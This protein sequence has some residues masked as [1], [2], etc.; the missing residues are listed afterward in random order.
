SLMEGVARGELDGSGLW[1]LSKDGE[2][3]TARYDWQVETTKPW[4]NLIAPLAR[5]LFKWNHD[6]VM[7]W[8]A[9]GLARRLDAVVIEERESR[10]YNPLP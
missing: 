6:I 5:P 2:Y 8:G 10:E 9:Q 1:N 4:M 3:T 7:K